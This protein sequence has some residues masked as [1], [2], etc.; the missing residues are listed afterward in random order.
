MTASASADTVGMADIRDVAPNVLNTLPLTVKYGDTA[1]V[2]GQLVG[3][4]QVAR[5]N[6]AL[7]AGFA[8]A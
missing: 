2:D 4:A 7:S 1:I 6:A 3:K 8:L 5:Q